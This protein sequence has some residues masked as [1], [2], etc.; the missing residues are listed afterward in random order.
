VT[1]ES[2]LSASENKVLQRI[3]EP[4]NLEVTVEQTKL[5]NQERQNL[6]SA[7]YSHSVVHSSGH[8]FQCRSN[9]EISGSNFDRS[10]DVLPVSFSWHVLRS[11]RVLPDT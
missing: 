4:M 10:T 1:E 8:E 2:E 5:L 11:E 9:T 3:L 7:P 6:Y